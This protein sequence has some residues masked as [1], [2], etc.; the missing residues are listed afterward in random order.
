MHAYWPLL[1]DT[2]NL[3][4][5]GCMVHAAVVNVRFVLMRPV[6][7][8]PESAAMRSK[9]GETSSPVLAPAPTPAPPPPA[10]PPPPG[11]SVRAALYHRLREALAQLEAPDAGSGLDVQA[12][13]C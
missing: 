7:P 13:L 8:S 12:W 6:P 4:L 1:F 2:S 3:C 11:S 9:S 10:P 5:A